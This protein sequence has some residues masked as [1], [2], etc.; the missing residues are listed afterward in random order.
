M[1]RAVNYIGAG[2][3][4]T[5]A[6][7]R[8]Y[9]PPNGQLNAANV[10]LNLTADPLIPMVDIS[11]NK[12]SVGSSVITFYV[13]KFSNSYHYYGYY[14]NFYEMPLFCDGKNPQVINQTKC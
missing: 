5:V 2:P 6:I 9:L 4:S 1:Y 11:W 10:T 7:M 13:I 3:N 8:N 14:P 12:S